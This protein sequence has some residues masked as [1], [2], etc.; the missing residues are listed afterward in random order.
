MI[1]KAN[2][3]LSTLHLYS[4]LRFSIAIGRTFQGCS[5]IVKVGN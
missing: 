5:F 1:G 2:L 4:P 3:S